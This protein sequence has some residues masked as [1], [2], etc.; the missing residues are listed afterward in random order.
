MI[1]SPI[2]GYVLLQIDTEKSQ[3]S[4]KLFDAANSQRAEQL[5][6]KK[7]KFYVAKPH[8]VM[9]LVS[10]TSVGGIREAYP[11]YFADSSEFIK[12]LKLINSIK[13]KAPRKP[14]NMPLFKS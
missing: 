3:L 10:T 12:L 6:G 2:T 14:L 13:A 5:Y 4:Y 7:E 9:A 8:I 11:N 1:D